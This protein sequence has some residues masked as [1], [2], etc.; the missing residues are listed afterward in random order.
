VSDGKRNILE[1]A[2]RVDYYDAA[3]PELKTEVPYTV[4]LFA[5]NRTNIARLNR[6]GI[7]AEENLPA[8]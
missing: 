8:A 1:A 2:T 4:E 7:T 5:A 6:A 3:N